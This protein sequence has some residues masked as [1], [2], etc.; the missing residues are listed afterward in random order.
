MNL[1]SFLVLFFL[2][3]FLNAQA[4]DVNNNQTLILKSGIYTIKDVE[5]KDNTIIK[6]INKF[7]TILKLG[8]N[9]KKALFYAK[10]KS[11]IEIS[12]LTILNETN[13]R[14][15]LFHFV[16]NKEQ[17]KNITIKNCIIKSP[18]AEADVIVFKKY[19]SNI[20][21]EDNIIE[22]KKNPRIRR[23]YKQIAV[24]RLQGVTTHSKNNSYIYI[25][26]NIIKYGNSGFR[27]AGK[28]TPPNPLWFENNVIQ[29]QLGCGAFFYHGARQKIINNYFS[30]IT[31]VSMKNNDGGVV[32]LDKYGNGDI[33][34]TG[35]TI[36]NNY[37]N[38]IYIEELKNAI[39][40]NNIIK[41]NFKRVNDTYKINNKGYNYNSDGGNGILITG[42][43]RGLQ[44]SNN[45]ILENASDGI[46]I[47]RNLGVQLNYS[48]P[49]LNINNN[50]ITN[51]KLYG[52]ETVG[53][54]DNILVRNNIVVSRYRQ[55]I[56][57]SKTFDMNNFYLKKYKS[58][59]L[60]HD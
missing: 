55:F 19:I 30:N 24:I 21:I 17:I 53:K 49:L 23:N 16:G 1:N 12:N 45:Q 35:N 43:I 5:L 52:I 8:K 41:N 14:V 32:W 15:P 42:G 36:E 10:D 50:L 59:F 6:G 48:I 18:K 47:N 11:N 9:A 3:L 57:S 54:V 46:L 31:A 34:F 2:S 4:F 29:G 39:V 22:A 28:G 26:N 33:L 25:K 60:N 58:K 44:V 51:N 37:G 38:G 40:S 13:Q 7:R 56:N 20:K 27:I